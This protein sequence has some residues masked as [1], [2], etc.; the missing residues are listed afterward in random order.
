VSGG[1]RRGKKGGQGGGEASV[2]HVGGG[3]GAP[4]AGKAAGAASRSSAPKA[5]AAA[6]ATAVAAA[7]AAAAA[8]ATA[9]ATAAASQTQGAAKAE[10]AADAASAAAE[11]NADAMVAHW[12]NPLGFEMYF[13]M[14]LS[15]VSSHIN[16]HVPSDEYY[17]L[18][19]NCFKADVQDTYL[20]S[21]YLHVDQGLGTILITRHLERKRCE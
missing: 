5:A 8:A 18:L 13:R 21:I 1:T 11:A 7:A 19:L 14:F 4:G 2:P 12:L 10:A 9:T 20:R 17:S 3:A 16:I 6:S 15:K